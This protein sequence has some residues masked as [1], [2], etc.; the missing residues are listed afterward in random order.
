MTQRGS[1]SAFWLYASKPAGGERPVR[2]AS[3]L[4]SASCRGEPASQRRN[5]RRKVREDTARRGDVSDGKPGDR[6]P[7]DIA[8]GRQGVVGDGMDGRR[9]EGRRE[10]CWGNRQRDVRA[11]AGSDAHLPRRP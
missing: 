9:N 11:N 6:K 4:D 2:N 7:P 5:P 8:P 10:I 3:E 1:S